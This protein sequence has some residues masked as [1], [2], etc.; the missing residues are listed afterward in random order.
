MPQ[1]RWSTTFLENG[2]CKILKSD[3]TQCGKQL[4]ARS[5]T[6]KGHIKSFHRAVYD[7]A[8]SRETV[9]VEGGDNALKVLGQFFSTTSAPMSYL[10]DTAFKV[11]LL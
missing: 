11:N 9:P 4:Q 3:G 6:V 1:I 10:K 7:E 2:K 8:M 5:T